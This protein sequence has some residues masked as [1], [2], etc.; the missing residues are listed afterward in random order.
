[1][2]KLSISTNTHNSRGVV[3]LNDLNALRQVVR[4][5]N[6]PR[7]KD[8]KARPTERLGAPNVLLLGQS[9]TAGVRRL[10]WAYH[11]PRGP[12]RRRHVLCRPPTRNDDSLFSVEIIA[13]LLSNVFTF[14]KAIAFRQTKQPRAVKQPTDGSSVRTRLWSN[15]GRRRRNISMRAPYTRFT[16]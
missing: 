15:R 16:R 4:T 10:R 6:R 12:R 3:V 14:T 11:T 1:L 2:Y 13:Q 7:I 5:V 8:G 9:S